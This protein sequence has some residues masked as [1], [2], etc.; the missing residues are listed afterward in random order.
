MRS[1]TVP[2]EI[3]D[4]LEAMNFSDGESTFGATAEAGIL[5]GG[6]LISAV[7]ALLKIV[8]Q[9]TALL[10]NEK[11]VALFKALPSILSA[12]MSGDLVAAFKLIAEVLGVVVPK[13]TT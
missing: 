6:G 5:G 13:P 8:P 7:S 10:G 12:L 3:A 2:D 4:A 9:L 1:V 11:L